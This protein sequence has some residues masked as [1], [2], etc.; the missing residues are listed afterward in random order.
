MQ[1]DVLDDLKIHSTAI[2]HRSGLTLD[3]IPFIDDFPIHCFIYSGFFI[4][5]FH[6]PG[7]CL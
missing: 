6:F 7:G 5:T 2:E 4:A 3:N 1:Y